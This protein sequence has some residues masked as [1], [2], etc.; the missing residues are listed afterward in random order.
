VSDRRDLVAEQARIVENLRAVQELGRSHFA[1]K[2]T[3]TFG[4]LSAEEWSTLL[5]KHLD[6]H[7]QQ[8]GA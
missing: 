5:L 2:A 3:P 4:V 6:H 8:S 1:G 7:L